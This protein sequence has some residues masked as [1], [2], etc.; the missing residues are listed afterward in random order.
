MAPGKHSIIVI[1]ISQLLKEG[2]GLI[3]FV[4]FSMKSG[5]KNFLLKHAE[6]YH[7]IGTFYFINTFITFYFYCATFANHYFFQASFS[8]PL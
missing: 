6:T 1:L 2:D 5:N 3:T 4:S 7:L 8:E